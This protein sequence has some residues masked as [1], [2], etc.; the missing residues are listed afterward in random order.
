M[1]NHLYNYCLRLADTSLIL[2][3]RLSEYSSHGPFLE[4]DLALTNV[5]LDLIGQAEGLFNYAATVKGDGTTA[6]EIAYKRDEVDYKNLHLVEFPNEDFAF[7]TVRQF[8]MDTYNFYLYTALKNSSDSTIAA[9]A[10]KSLKEVTYHLKRSSE[11]MLRLGDGTEESHH[12]IRTAVNHLWMYTD[13]LFD[14][15]NTDEELIS[16]GI[17]VDLNE[18]KEKWNQKVDS[19][20]SE[21]TLSQPEHTKHSL[22]YGKKGGHTEYMGYILNDMQYLTNRYPTATW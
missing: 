15:D 22:V 13:E 7:I 16:K 5:G 2:S 21:A 10:A 8:L 9:I 17:A 6:D 11:W 1:E 19:V 14:M 3:Y 4:E 18:I 12:K 20:L